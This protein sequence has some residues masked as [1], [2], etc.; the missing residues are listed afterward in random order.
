MINLLPWRENLRRKRRRKIFLGMGMVLGML[1][2]LAV[3]GRWCVDIKLKTAQRQL[4]EFSGELKGLKKEFELR[5]LLWVEQKKRMAQWDE[6]QSWRK[7]FACQQLWLKNLAI[8]LPKLC[9]MEKAEVN[10][11]RWQVVIICQQEVEL[12][13]LVQSLLGLQGLSQMNISQL[14]IDEKRGVFSLVSNAV[15][16]CE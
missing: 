2:G 6:Q 7:E 5:D 16:K 1:V 14:E 8:Q 3:I 11:E 9:R 12:Q 10:S 15:L 13:V 4:T